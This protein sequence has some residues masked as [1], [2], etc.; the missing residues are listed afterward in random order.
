LV[1]VTTCCAAVLCI[2]IMRMQHNSYD[3]TGILATTYIVVYYSPQHNGWMQNYNNKSIHHSFVLSI[4]ATDESRFTVFETSS[5][6]VIIVI[7][8]V[9]IQYNICARLWGS[10]NVVIEHVIFIETTVYNIIRIMQVRRV[11]FNV[12]ASA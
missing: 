5:A 11:Y 2:I 7:V 3:P 1:F 4:M 12:Y 6:N 8:C 10:A 9:F